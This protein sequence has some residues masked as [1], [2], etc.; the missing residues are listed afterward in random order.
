MKKEKFQPAQT[1]AGLT[2]GD[3]VRVTREL[4]E[5]TQAELAERAGLTQ[6][7]VS[8]IEKGRISLGVERAKKL[9]KALRVHPAVLLFPDW[10]AEKASA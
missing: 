2:V 10:A 6:P 3:T 1:Y 5:L 4:Q 9:A 7:V 8:A